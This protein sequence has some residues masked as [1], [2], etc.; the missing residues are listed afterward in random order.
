MS[1]MIRRMEIRGMKQ[2]GFKRLKLRKR[3]LPDGTSIVERVKR[4]PV[5][6][7]SGVIVGRSWPRVSA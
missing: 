6:D 7:P 1:S 4:G 2:R 3:Q 5:V